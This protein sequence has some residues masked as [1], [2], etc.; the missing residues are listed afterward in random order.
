[1]VEGIT[2]AKSALANWIGG[3]GREGC[4][5]SGLLGERHGGYSDQSSLLS[6]LTALQFDNFKRVFKVVEEMRGSLVDN[7]QQHFLLSDRLAR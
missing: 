6:T 1:M 4:S 3:W 7:I 2:D 5:V